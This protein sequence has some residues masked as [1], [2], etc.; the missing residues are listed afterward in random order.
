MKASTLKRIEDLQKVKDR[1]SNLIDEIIVE[2]VCPDRKV[3]STL[4]SRKQK[5]GSWEKT[6]DHH[7]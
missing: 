1:D 6:W 3:T 5:D 2:F 4:I 7:A